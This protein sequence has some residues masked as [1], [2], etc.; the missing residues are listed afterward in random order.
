MPDTGQ[1]GIMYGGRRGLL[2]RPIA[3]AVI[4]AGKYLTKGFT[5]HQSIEWKGVHRHGAGRALLKPVL[6]A[7][8]CQ[9]KRD[10]TLLNPVRHAKTLALARYR[11]VKYA[12]ETGLKHADKRGWHT[13]LPTKL[14][15]KIL[16]EE[17]YTRFTAARNDARDKPFQTEIIAQPLD[18]WDNIRVD[19]DTEMDWWTEEGIVKTLP[20]QPR[21]LLR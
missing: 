12:E 11:I 2:N 16:G 7:R 20:R 18:R 3:D 19:T 5:T 15:E 4:Y 14:T 13:E 10:G 21:Y 9:R 1:K 8:I 17:L 6:K